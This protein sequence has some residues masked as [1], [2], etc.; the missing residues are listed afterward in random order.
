MDGYIF[1]S[2]ELFPYTTISNIQNTVKHLSQMFDSVL[3]ELLV[4]P[5]MQK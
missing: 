4:E 2:D 5:F 3:N 1:N